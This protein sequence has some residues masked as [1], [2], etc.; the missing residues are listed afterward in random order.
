MQLDS[1]MATTKQY[2]LHNLESQIRDS[3]WNALSKIVGIIIW[4]GMSNMKELQNK[5]NLTPTNPKNHC[6]Q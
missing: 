4:I 3:I 5:Q 1:K 6:S 2:I